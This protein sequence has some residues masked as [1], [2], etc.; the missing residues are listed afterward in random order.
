MSLIIRVARVD[1]AQAF[2]AIYAPIV[3]GTHASFENE[4][5]NDAEME[6]RI[7]STLEQTPW[8]AAECDGAIA[9]YAYAGRHRERAGYRW[10]VD[11]SVYLD[12]R[13]RGR[14]IGRALYDRLLALLEQQGFRRA[15]AGVALPND[16]SV[17]LHRALGFE[18]IGIYRRVGWK[19]GRWYDVM[20]LGRDVGPDEGDAQPPEPIPFARLQ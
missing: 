19:A 9:G 5:P 18:P 11:V 20:W 14:G 4:P 13:F 8:L 16:A 1:D 2:A 15:Y 7:R 12:E 17:G 10:A 3:A 6:R